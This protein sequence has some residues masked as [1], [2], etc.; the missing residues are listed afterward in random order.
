MLSFFPV[1]FWWW[2]PLIFATGWVIGYAHFRNALH[3]DHPDLYEQWLN[4]KEKK[5]AS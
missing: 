2:I 4:R 3:R 5:D 1:D